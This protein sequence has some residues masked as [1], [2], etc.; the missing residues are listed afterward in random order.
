MKMHKFESESSSDSSFEDSQSDKD[1][2]DFNEFHP[3][4]KRRLM[5]NSKEKSA[6]GV[7]GSESEDEVPGKRWKGKINLRKKGVSFVASTGHQRSDTDDDD[8]DIANSDIFESSIFSSD[9]NSM[10]LKNNPTNHSTANNLNIPHG[11]I[12]FNK[13]GFQVA[14]SIFSSPLEGS[15]K[16]SP[17]N[18]KE[19]LNTPRNTSKNDTRSFAA[20]MMSKMGYKEGEGLGKDGQGRNHVIE[21]TLRPQGVGLGA[22]KEKP[23][24]EYEEEKRQAKMR[25]EKYEDPRDL[26]KKNQKIGQA[27]SSQIR[28]KDNHKQSQKPK[29]KTLDE[30]QKVAPG[31][32]IP[33]SYISI[34][35]MTAPDPKLL[36]STSG[37][38]NTA[39]ENKNIHHSGLRKIFK[40]A[41]NDL[42]AYVE[43]W[44]N[45]EERKAFVR[46]SISQKR[47]EIQE[48]Q[49]Q[50][51]V[52]QS[53]LT[54]FQL[55]S[56][57]ETEFEWDQIT[58]TLEDVASLIGSEFSSRSE[59][60]SKA[61]VAIVHPFV[62]RAA[63]GWVPLDD[64][65]LSGL[66]LRLSKIR[67]VLELNPEEVDSKC[68]DVTFIDM[69]SQKS[70]RS[71]TVYESMIFKIIYPKIL[72]TIDQNWDVFDPAS[73]QA[74]LEVW[75]ELLPQ[76]VKIQILNQ[77]VVRRLNTAVTSWNPKKRKMNELPHLW[78]FPWLQYLPPHHS[79]PKS[80]EGLVSDIKRKFRHLVDSWDFH[81]GV[82]PGLH[83]W[84]EVLYINSKNDQWTPLIMNHV[85]PS[86][87]KFLKNEK[88]FMVDP[89]DQAPF[90]SSLEGIF[91]WQR[92]IS[93]RIISQVLVDTVFPLWHN[94]LYKWL[95]FVGPNE[96]IGQ[97]FEWWR[98]EVFPAEIKNSKMIQDQFNKGHEMIKQALDLGPDASSLLPTPSL[99]E[100]S[101]TLSPVPDPPPDS[102]GLDNDSLKCKI[103]DWCIEND[104]Q[105][106]PEKKIIHSVGPLHRITAAGNGKNGAL[107]YIKGNKIQAISKKGLRQIEIDINWENSDS[108]DLLLGM[109]WHNVK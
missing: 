3:R 7:F 4:K 57:H 82:V 45:L 72:Y 49:R 105:F 32:D 97:W 35:D 103:E 80:S 33:Q 64:P 28:N 68:S 58:Q 15:S 71:S 86:M 88:N 99:P 102:Q 81:K 13:G 12:P 65:G 19:S 90:M 18:F 41:Q 56:H 2:T 92:I 38:M 89:N 60:L 47:Q 14:S 61:A 9:R 21:V 10:A 6:L 1:E 59:D 70:V 67:K 108:K 50:F 104:L 31:L 51:D 30:I 34:L 26:I 93:P 98:H 20:R 53:S 24:Q 5:T 106:L 91:E 25:G 85:L 109:A 78:L 74:L 43:E 39:H 69:R 37:I 42:S 46:L 16:N 77:G 48:E 75:Q 101:S 36:T 11:K 96:E 63:E 107:V 40:S 84:R 83:Q 29:Y 8:A 95:V 44:K 62:R 73:L 94:V 54:K 66:A 100:K 23:D 79:D 87:S 27:R 22:V 55:F 52:V 76:F 17:Q